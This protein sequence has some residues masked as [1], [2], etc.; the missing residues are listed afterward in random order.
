MNIEESE[1][2]IYHPLG[3]AT[4]TWACH[5][6]SLGLSEDPRKITS[7]NLLKRVIFI[8]PLL[9]SV[10]QSDFIREQFNQDL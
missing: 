9:F 8:S 1:L 3:L 10:V 6:A 7:K 4:S 5:V 2:P